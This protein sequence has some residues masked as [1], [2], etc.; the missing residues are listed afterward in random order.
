MLVTSVPSPLP[1]CRRLG[2]PVYQSFPMMTHY[3][4]DLMFSGHAATTAL[5]VVWWL[6]QPRHC[7]QTKLA[8]VGVGAVELMVI[9]GTHQH[10]TADVLVGVYIGCLVPL[11]RRHTMRG[12]WSQNKSHPTEESHGAAHTD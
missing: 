4:N 8:A 3:C 2:S 12:L 11:C 6:L 1:M 10:Y 9:I 7:W 5:C